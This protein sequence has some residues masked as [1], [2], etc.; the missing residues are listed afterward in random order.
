MAVWFVQ[1][2]DDEDLGPLRPADLLSLVRDGS[3]TADSMLRK[4]DSA[5]FPASD[6]GGLFEAARRPTI[7]HF[8]PD[9]NVRVNQPPT[10]CPRCGKDLLKTKTRI[11]EHSFNDGNQGAGQPGQKS[12]SAKKW[13]Q[14]KMRGN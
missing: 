5:W 11:I 13:L 7:E 10:T 2:E 8:C 6:V 9:C 1:R 14:K 12:A 4:D 3:V